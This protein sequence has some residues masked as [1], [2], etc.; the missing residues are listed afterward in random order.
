[1]I[2]NPVSIL[3]ALIAVPAGIICLMDGF[4]RWSYYNTTKNTPTSKVEA[5][6]AGFVEVYGEAIPKGDYF[7]SPFS[8]RE[9]TFYTYTIEEDSGGKGSWLSLKEGCSDSP[10]FVE[11]GT[12]KIEVDPKDAEV[13]VENTKT[14]EVRSKDETP[15]RIKEFLS[16]IN[17]PEKTPSLILGPIRDYYDRRYTEC[18][19]EEGEKV[20]VTGTAVPKEGVLSERHEDT[21]FIKKGDLNEFFYVSDKAEKGALEEIKKR[22]IISFICGFLVAVI[23]LAYTFIRMNIL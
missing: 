4:K 5:V 19:I 13:K 17:I 11:D 23:G 9:C 10:F 21:L 6:A 2:S 22:A 1:M 14:F 18:I 8:G 15:P 3:Y 7:K 12:G 20:F 16:E